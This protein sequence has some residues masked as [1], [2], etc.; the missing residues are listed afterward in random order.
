MDG[1]TG[2]WTDGSGDGRAG[3]TDGLL[4]GWTDSATDLRGDRQ[5]VWGVGMTDGLVA[6]QTDV[7][8]DGR[9]MRQTYRR[10]GGGGGARWGCKAVKLHIHF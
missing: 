4:V 10:S 1:V 3:M 9:F 8:K 2:G 5:T 6:R 7:E